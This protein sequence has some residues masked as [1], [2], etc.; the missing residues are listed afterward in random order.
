MN[1]NK[2]KQLG[3]I[4]TINGPVLFL[5]GPIGTYFSRLCNYLEKENIKSYKVVFPLK[6]FGFK[7]HQRIHFNHDMKYF[8]DFLLKVIEERKIRHI[9]MYGDILIPHKIAIETCN[10][11][12]NRGIDITTDIF[13]LGYLRPNYVTLESNNVNFKSNL[14][15]DRIYYEKL[16]SIN[17]LPKAT[18]KV[19]IRYRKIWKGIT[20]V[21]HAFTKYKIIDYNHKLQPKPIYLYYQVLGLIRKYYYAIK[22]INI[23]REIFNGLPFYLVVL[24]V[25]TDSQLTEGSEFNSV[26]DFIDYVIQEFKKSKISKHRLIFKHHPRDRGYNNYK[27][28]IRKSVNKHNLEEKVIYLHDTKIATLLRQ[29]SCKGSV[30]INSSVGIQSL[31]HNIPVKALSNAIYNFDGLTDQSK[32]VNFFKKPL[33]PDQELFKKF[34]VYIHQETQIN[35]NFDGFFPFKEVFNIDKKI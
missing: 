15:K 32:L 1:K 33:G 3:R 21:M 19:G 27:D 28:A 8:K 24:Q 14:P 35:G 25:S 20:F 6:E 9:F 16:A 23:K 29:K 11:L 17:K 12:R 5:M 30:M 13:E 2:I 31:F 18:Y 26:E 4:K 22:E 34:F 7:K 10:A